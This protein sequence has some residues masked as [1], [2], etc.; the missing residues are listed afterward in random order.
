MTKAVI[1]RFEGSV[2]ILLLGDTAQRMEIDRK[3]LPKE[4]R[5]GHWLEIEIRDGKV[6]RAELDQEETDKRKLSIAE[7]LE[8]LRRGE[9]R[10]DKL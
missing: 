8:R 2:A 4:A 5:E 10:Q 1:D 9:Q 3:L 7:K 6:Y